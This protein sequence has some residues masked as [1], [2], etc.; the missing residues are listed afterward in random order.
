V[1]EE[2]LGDAPAR[3]ALAARASELAAGE[4]SWGEIGRRTLALYDELLAARR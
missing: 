2:M 1:L 4:Y 3:D